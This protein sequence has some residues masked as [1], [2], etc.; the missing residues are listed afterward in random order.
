MGKSIMF[1]RIFVLAIFIFGASSWIYNGQLMPQANQNSELAV[2]ESRA[3]T[4]SNWKTYS[5]S[6]YGLSFSYPS[7][8][9]DATLL[10]DEI[11]Y[12]PLEKIYAPAGSVGHLAKT[13]IIFS[14]KP[15][16]GN[17]G[18]FMKFDIP[19][20]ARS[21][22]SL[23]VCGINLGS[24]SR[25]LA[26]VDSYKS[27]HFNQA[28]RIETYKTRL[29]TPIGTN[30]VIFYTLFNNAN[31]VLTIVQPTASFNPAGSSK[32][33]EEIGKIEKEIGH[34]AD[35]ILWFI[36]NSNNASQI[37]KYFIDL[38][39]ITQSIKFLP[40]NIL[41]TLPADDYPSK[42]LSPEEIP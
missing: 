2:D 7:Y 1:W 38:E 10:E 40:E 39:K 23:E 35:P 8:L 9:G 29:A 36:N 16:V 20:I 33:S 19:V 15:P 30:A 28:N 13:K 3:H 12:C 4:D 14:K 11:F 17:E 37:K 26:E 6:R 21:E 34:Q 22:S 5:S 18:S 41:E 27:E 31:R 42:W 25:N 32:E 24:L